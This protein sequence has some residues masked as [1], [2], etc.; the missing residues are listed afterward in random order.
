MGRNWRKIPL[1]LTQSALIQPNQFIPGRIR[2][3]IDLLAR[4]ISVKPRQRLAYSFSKLGRRA[5]IRHKAFDL[6]VVE[7]NTHRLIAR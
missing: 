3:L 6:G 5:K 4:G 7:D 1:N 2:F